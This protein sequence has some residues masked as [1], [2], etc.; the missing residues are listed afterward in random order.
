MRILVTGGAG[1]IGSNLSIALK[2]K[3]HK[4][5]VLDNF[6]SGTY[7]NLLGFSGEVIQKDL[8]SLKF[9][10]LEEIGADA[11]FHQ[12]AITDTTCYDEK[13]MFQ[14]NTKSFYP[15]LDYCELTNS[16]LIYASS[17]AVYGP[18][19]SPQIES[20]A[21]FPL[22]VYGY[23][24]YAMD[25]ILFNRLNENPNLRA[26]G[27]RYF[28]VFGPRESYKGKMASMV[29]QLYN[30]IKSGKNPKIFKWGEQS[31]D[32]IYVKDVV[33]A[34]LHALKKLESS[35]LCNV[36]NLGSG[37]ATSFKEILDYLSHSMNKKFEIDFID[38]PYADKYQNH[39]QASIELL[40]KELG[41]NPRWHAK[42]AIAD[43][44]KYLDH[45]SF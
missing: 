17:A 9:E 2:E 45:V 43:Y 11:I 30:Q 31:R 8:S 22:N 28:N 4:V 38:N 35:P 13:L 41:F 36:Y 25:Q 40:K 34:N 10:D 3:G 6:S 21:G 39:T 32:F 20:G 23:S 16:P 29:F 7:K 18:L 1:F 15:I 37:N 26:I 19:K 42:D 5:V 44:V 24:K 14:V 12:G 33:D 27:F